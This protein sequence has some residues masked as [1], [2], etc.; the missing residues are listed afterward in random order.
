MRV[1]ARYFLHR[2]AVWLTQ[3][4][5]FFVE[6][7]SRPGRALRAGGR[8]ALRG[9]HPNRDPRDHV[10]KASTQQPSGADP[11]PVAE[12]ASSAVRRPRPTPRVGFGAGV[13]TGEQNPS[14]PARRHGLD[15][16]AAC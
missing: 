3:L 9:M 7:G 8:P 6:V 13:T 5:L 1:P 16:S 2:L 4:F 12:D 15:R 11:S 10:A 14:E